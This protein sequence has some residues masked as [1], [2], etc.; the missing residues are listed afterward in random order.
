[1]I[2]IIAIIL[3]YF[4]FTFSLSALYG[5]AFYMLSLLGGIVGIKII[6]F[7]ILI[8]AFEIVYEIPIN[9]V[10]AGVGTM[11]RKRYP[12]IV[13][14]GL[15]I[16]EIL[17]RQYAFYME[18]NLAWWFI[19]PGITAI[20]HSGIMIATSSTLDT[21]SEIERVEEQAVGENWSASEYLTKTKDA[22]VKDRAMS[23]GGILVL[24][25]AIVISLLIT[26]FV[27]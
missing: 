13:I 10:V 20:I 25:A 27:Y 23:I 8:I 5:L 9:V 7:I 3:G 24:V 18:N 15:M 1:M 4:A 16:A 17:Y 26:Y 12:I 2:N 11:A 19:I 22:K 21:M 6:G 14:C